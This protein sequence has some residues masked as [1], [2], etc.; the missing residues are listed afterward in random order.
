MNFADFKVNASCVEA[1]T[2]QSIIT[3]TPVQ[4]TAI[5]KIL[6]GADLIAVAQTGTGKTLAYALPSITKIVNNP[7][8]G[9]QMLILVPTRE[10]CVQVYNVVRDMAEVAGLS[11]AQIYGGVGYD[12]QTK[13]LKN[14]THIIIATPGRLLDHIDRRN[15]NFKN[16]QFLVLDEADRMLDM[17]FLPDVKE[18]I[19]YTNKSRQTLMFSATFQDAIARLAQ[20]MMTDPEKIVIGVI[21]KPV[22][23]VTQRLYPVL[24]ERKPRLI[25]DILTEEEPASCMIFMR[26]KVRTE[27]VAAILKNK[28]WKVAQ[29]HGDRSQGQ[30]QQALDGFRTGKYKVLVATDVASRGIDIDG[31]SHVINYDIPLNPDDYIHRIG[32]TARADA[33]GDAYTLVTPA[34]FQALGSIEKTLGYNI[35]RKEREGAPRV[36]SVFNPNGKKVNKARRGRSLLRRR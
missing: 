14:G 20:N 13:A 18:I 23:T 1:L 10:L 9:T 24:D 17:G 28:G 26:T 4:E 8:K 19:T 6:Q 32:R 25:A 5:P 15:A 31:V 2:K 33:K 7:G 34:E 29:L 16:I 3:P 35:P 30:R 27:Q 36:L 12:N 22:D 11:A 21:A